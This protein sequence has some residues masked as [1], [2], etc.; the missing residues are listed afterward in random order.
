MNIYGNPYKVIEYN[1]WNIP[2][3]VWWMPMPKIPKER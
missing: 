2:G 1:G 3:V